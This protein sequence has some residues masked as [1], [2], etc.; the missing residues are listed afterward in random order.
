M[1]RR[2]ENCTT[3]N[4][5]VAAYRH[6]TSR[7]LELQKHTHAVAANLIYEGVEGRWKAEQA[8]GL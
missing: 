7:E 1:G 5:I 6:D 8:S 3:C 2:T 4:V